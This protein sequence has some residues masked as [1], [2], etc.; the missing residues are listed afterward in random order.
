[1]TKT[2]IQRCLSMNDSGLDSDGD[3]LDQLIALR[4]KG[5]PFVLTAAIPAAIHEEGG[6][7]DDPSFAVQIAGGF[8]NT[9]RTELQEIA[10]NKDNTPANRSLAFIMMATD[11]CNLALSGALNKASATKNKE[12][13]SAIAET[14]SDLW[15]YVHEDDDVSH[16]K[17]E[18]LH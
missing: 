18:T 14:V 4:D 5:V 15:E 17:K 11:R 13:F 6:N 1:M 3:L 7:D 2:L 12:V 16:D 8:V 10:E 9:P